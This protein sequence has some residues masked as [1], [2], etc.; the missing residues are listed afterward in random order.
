MK[1][2][3]LKYDPYKTYKITYIIGGEYHHKEVTG[4]K[5]EELLMKLGAKKHI[6]WIEEK[7]IPDQKSI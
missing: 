7:Y 4:G 5:V 1:T 2:K 3:Q 6:H